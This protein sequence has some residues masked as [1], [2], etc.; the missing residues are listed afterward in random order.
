MCTQWR[1]TAAGYFLF[2]VSY[3]TSRIPW[4]NYCCHPRLRDFTY[5]Q[6]SRCN[7]KKF[8]RKSA[9]T[10]SFRY[11]FFYVCWIQ[12]PN[13]VNCRNILY[14]YYFLRPS[15]IISNNYWCWYLYALF[16]KLI[17]T[18]STFKL[19]ILYASKTDNSMNRSPCLLWTSVKVSKPIP[20]FSFS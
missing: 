20:L 12:L 6:R 7:S 13:S 19:V 1:Y 2:L 16:N 15:L 10:H 18:S 17:D 8:T 5:R 11:G 14:F 3:S 9:V 4:F